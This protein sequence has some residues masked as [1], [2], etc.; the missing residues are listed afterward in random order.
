MTR[1]RMLAALLCL[2]LYL[3]WTPLSLAKVNV[4]WQEGEAWFPEGGDWTYHYT[5]RFPLAEGEGEAQDCINYYFDNAWNEMTKLVLPMYAADPVMSGG[6]RHE[7]SQAYAL[8]CNNDDFFSFLLT[9]HQTVAGRDLVSLSSAV[10]AVSGEY[11]GQTLTLRGLVQVGD[12]SRQ[13]AE[14]V[15]EDIWR[16]ISARI[17]AGDSA[18]QEELSKE[19]LAA[20]FYPETQFYADEE[21]RAVFYLQPGEFR[22]D[23]QVITFAYTAAEILSLL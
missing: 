13:L 22:T 10:F 20:E 17:A 4:A 15:L 16:Q 12:S 19:K 8:T 5:Y 2:A 9:Q 23:D 21:G 14:A 6:L 1:E 3:S 18:W 11:L 7:F